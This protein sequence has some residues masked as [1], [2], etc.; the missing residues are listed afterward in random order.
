MLQRHETDNGYFVVSADLYLDGRTE[1]HQE[2]TGLVWLGHQD[3]MARATVGM[4]PDT[5]R[6]LAEMLLQAARETDAAMARPEVP[7]DETTSR[8]L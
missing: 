2:S 4:H 8:E 7:G 6:R 3:G 1:Q 5:A